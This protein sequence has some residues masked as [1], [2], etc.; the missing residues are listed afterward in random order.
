[1]DEKY[2]TTEGENV[3]GTD[4]YLRIGKDVLTTTITSSSSYVLEWR[5]IEDITTYELA[6][7]TPV[8][9]RMT[10]EYLFDK[11]TLNVC[12][13][14]MRHFNIKEVSHG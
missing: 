6:Q 13:G 8:L 4:S 14:Y 9:I 7:C 11:L 10:R 3:L 1:M 5:P 12:A 2:Y